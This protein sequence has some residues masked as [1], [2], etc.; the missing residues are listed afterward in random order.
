[1]LA[2]ALALLG[3]A[4]LE[5][6]TILTPVFKSPYRAFRRSE[7]GGYISDPGQG[8]SI[9]LQGEYRVARPKFDFGLTIGYLDGQGS[10]SSIFGVGIDGRLPVSRHTRDFPLDVSVTGA[11]GAL[12]GDGSTGFAVPFGATLGR[13]VLLENSSVSFTPYVHP[14]IAPTF[15]DLLSDVQFGFGLGVDISLT[16]TFDVRVSG[17]LG[18]IEGVAVGVAWH[19]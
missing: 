14:V 13:Q 3:T 16:R 1:M 7:L 8:V 15:G 17:S 12:F 18:D 2:F 5:A 4:A 9:A 11:F 6:Q 19:R 10:S